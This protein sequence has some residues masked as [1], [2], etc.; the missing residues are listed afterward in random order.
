M[1]YQHIIEEII[2]GIRILTINRPEIENKLNIICM[3]ELVEALKN[4][5]EDKKCGAI[6]LTG[7]G[8]YFCNGGELGDFRV[9]GPMEIREFGK[10]FISLHTTIIELS[11]PVIAAIQGHALGGGF[12]LVEACDFAVASENVTFGIP[13]MKSGLAPMMGLAGIRRMFSRKR[14]MELALLSEIICAD[15][16]IE[17]GVVNWIVPKEKVREKSM[18]IA[19]RLCKCNPTGIELCKKLYHTMDESEYRSHME[20]GLSILISVLKC[21]DATEVLNAKEESREPVWS[22]R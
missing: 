21:T 10:G 7:R 2:G 11:K 14:V 5:E 15:R 4:A 12:S 22:G 3:K 6:V 20:S 18:E 19:E 1:T 13:E 16:A 17:L 9:K 8:E